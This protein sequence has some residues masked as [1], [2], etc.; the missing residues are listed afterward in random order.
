MRPRPDAAARSGPRRM[1]TSAV[2]A[3][4]VRD[5]ALRAAPHHEVVAGKGRMG[6]EDAGVA[7]PHVITD[8]A[9]L[10]EK[11]MPI[12]LMDGHVV[13]CNVFRPNPGNLSDLFE[14]GLRG[15]A[16][17]APAAPSPRRSMA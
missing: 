14:T 8:G 9:I 4:M 15:R 16:E 10:I 2:Y 6:M 12:P 1:A 5:A 7:A 3:A 11:D 17:D 13:Y